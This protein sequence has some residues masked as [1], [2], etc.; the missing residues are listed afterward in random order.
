LGYI[1]WSRRLFCVSNC[2]TELIAF[3]YFINFFFY[4]GF[5][6]WQHIIFIH[7]RYIGYFWFKT[8]IPNIPNIVCVQSTICGIITKAKYYFRYLLKPHGTHCEIYKTIWVSI[9]KKNVVLNLRLSFFKKKIIIMGKYIGVAQPP[10]FGLEVGQPPPL[11]RG[12][13]DQ[14]VWGWPNHPRGRSPP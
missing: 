10:P 9:G 7:D 5:N 2:Y 11:G 1:N 6:F 3:F 4:E 8:C 14:P 12:V 13:A